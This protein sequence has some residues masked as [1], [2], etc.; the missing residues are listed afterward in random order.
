MRWD[1]ERASEGPVDVFDAGDELLCLAL[2]PTDDSVF[3]TGSTDGSV[4]I[5]DARSAAAGPAQVYGRLPDPAG[6]ARKKGENSNS[7]QS[8][9]NSKPNGHN[10]DVNSVCFFPSGSAVVTGSADTTVRLFDL[11][12]N[13]EL[14]MY[15]TH[16]VAGGENEP[17]EVTSVAV[18]KSG[19]YVFG[20]TDWGAVRVWDALKTTKVAD[21][22]HPRRVD[23]IAVSPDGFGLATGSWDNNV[24][25]W[26]V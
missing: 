12:A 9:G 5:W 7:A 23:N 6:L 22:G 20:A 10:A 15:S 1:A 4:L 16:G 24:R 18:S 8:V 2:S 21:L 3:A 26:S 13:R 19:Q 14:A 11:R 17:S 25:I